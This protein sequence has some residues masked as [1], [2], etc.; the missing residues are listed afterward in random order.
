M[1]TIRPASPAE[2]PTIELIARATWP[3]AYGEIL[4][5]EQIS[6]MLNMM[7]SP[8]AIADQVA[9]GQ[10]FYLLETANMR[11]HSKQVVGYVS[12]QVDYLPGTTKIHKLYALPGVQGQGFGRRMVEH[13]K[14]FAAAAGQQKLRLDVNYKNRAIGFYEKLGFERKERCNTDIGNGYL[15]EDWVMEMPL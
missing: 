2:Y 14:E 6:Y 4:T 8:R 15:M 7:Y 9:A 1:T 11:T 3:S 13:V 10:E 12:H 5:P